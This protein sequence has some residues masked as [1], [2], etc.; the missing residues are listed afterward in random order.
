MVDVSEMVDYDEELNYRL[1]LMYTL[2]G[3]QE[4]EQLAEQLVEY[5]ELEAKG[6]LTGSQN[7]LGL[8]RELAFGKRAIRGGC[9][10]SGKRICLG[11]YPCPIPSDLESPTLS[12]NS[13]R[14]SFLLLK[15]AWGFNYGS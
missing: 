6:V 4:A 8:I 15:R 9:N 7:R 11:F 5:G 13:A 2:S 1:N 14:S 12:E 3:Q 10:A